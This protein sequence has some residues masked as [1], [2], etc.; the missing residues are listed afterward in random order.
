MYICML[1]VFTSLK[2]R[3]LPHCRPTHQT[4]LHWCIFEHYCTSYF[5][6][7]S[8]CLTSVSYLQWKQNLPPSNFTLCFQINRINTH[9][10]HIQP[11]TRK[12]TSVWIT[13]SQKNSA[14][15]Q[16]NGA[17]NLFSTPA[18]KKIGTK[19]IQ[20]RFSSAPFHYS[21]SLHYS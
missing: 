17:S 12:N 13:S 3:A 20:V 6:I 10:T 16:P 1:K 21:S 8:T 18:Q 15:T 4:I 2:W 7:H 14:T 5:L 9:S 19:C 11:K